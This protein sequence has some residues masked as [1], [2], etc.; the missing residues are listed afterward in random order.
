MANALS[1]TA[2]NII[3]SLGIRGATVAEPLAGYVPILGPDGKLS[4]EFI[5]ADAAQMAIPPLSNVVFVDPY[6]DVDEDLQKGS[7]A[8]PYK[9]LSKAA[10]R[11]KSTEVGAS[12]L[13]LSF[14]LAPGIY[15]EP[16]VSFSHSPETEFQKAPRNVYFIGIGQCTFLNNLAIVGMDTSAGQSVLFQN[17]VTSGTVSVS[18]APVVTCLGNT[19]IAN[20]VIGDSE[21]QMGTLK[22][23]PESR[24][25]STNAANVVM[26]AD[27]AHVA[28]DLSASGVAGST[29]S[30]ALKRLGERKIRIARVSK[31]SSGFDVGSSTVDVSA[32]S[33]GSF[34]VYDI[35]ASH[36][37][38]A[39]GINEMFRNGKFSSVTADVVTATS[40]VA[41]NASIR[42]LDIDA[43]TLGGYSIEIDAY[44]Y[45]VVVDGST[46]TPAPPESVIMLED[47]TTGATYVLGVSRG[48]LYLKLESDEGSSGADV[49]HAI[50][51][52]DPDDANRTYDIYV[53]NGRLMIALADDSSSS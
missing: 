24:V 15:D 11:F 42:N 50:K 47:V 30:D 31:G 53:D 22:L 17:V 20:L 12:A 8:A 46:P 25:S 28:N 37:M 43:L 21:S 26:M 13:R 38:L 18:G 52:Y 34:D 5:P 40:V 29:V 2:A 49:Q 33:A 39:E 48:R 35:S 7:A 4:A 51:V 9:S 23:S 1:P 32:S 3:S 41:T 6:T 27:A 44:G 36:R 19:S 14:L 10:A 16:T 45:L